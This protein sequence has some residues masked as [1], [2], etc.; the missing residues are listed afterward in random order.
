MKSEPK[1]TKRVSYAKYGYIFTL[2]FILAFLIF[3]LYPL[4]FTTT[5]GFTDMEGPVMLGAG[6]SDTTFTWNTVVEGSNTL[7]MR[8]RVIPDNVTN[9]DVEWSVTPLTGDAAISE[10][11]L[12]TALSEGTVLVR[13]TAADGTGVFD[14]MEITIR[15]Q[16]IPDEIAT[17]NVQLP[18]NPVT[19]ISI[20]GD[21]GATGISVDSGSMQIYATI[22]PADANQNITWSVRQFDGNAT[23]N[24]AGSLTARANGTVFVRATANDGS[25]VYD[26]IEITI[27]GQSA[28]SISAESVVV[29][30]VGDADTIFTEDGTLNPFFWFIDVLN[31][32]LFRTAFA[33]TIFIWLLNFIPQI[34]LALTLASWFTN[35]LLRIKLVGFYKILFYMPNIITAASIA[36]LFSTLFG[37]P[38]GPANDLMVRLGIQE[39][40][41]N[42]LE[43]VFAEPFGYSIFNAQVIVAFIQFWMWY[44]VTMIILIAGIMGISPTL[45]EAAA[46]DGASHFKTFRYIT[47]PSLRTI[48]LFT[49]VTSFVGGMQMFDIPRMFMDGRPQNSTLTTSLFIFHQAFEGAQRYNRSAAASMIMFVF[50]CAVSGVLFYIM[51][52]KDAARLR[53][54]VRAKEKAMRRA[55]L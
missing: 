30:G 35:K 29:S 21:G 18:D 53:R 4:I 41:V 43:R 12:L 10:G 25:G 7:Q 37:H 16:V 52:D 5:I 27:S 36:L 33:N 48:L 51:R 34:L 31:S 3:Q 47:L 32:E 13:A 2:P 23:I 8:G 28:P 14:E 17:A 15:G 44:G 46:I 55:G 50:I 49:L 54:E 26:E 6:L 19:S 24:A 1:L 9:R 45:F 38:I 39:Y 20:S 42:I 11:G 22:L 40:S